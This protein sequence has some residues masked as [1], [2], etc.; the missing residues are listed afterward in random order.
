MTPTRRTDQDRVRRRELADAA[1]GW[2]PQRGDLAYDTLR[3]VSGVV[4]GLPEDTGTSLHQLV[5]EGGGEGWSA[6]VTRL[7]DPVDQPEDGGAVR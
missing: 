5:P 4:V 3:H 1:A 6:P 2:N 7:V